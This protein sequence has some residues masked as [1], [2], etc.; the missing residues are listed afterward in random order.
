MR[1]VLFTIHGLIGDAIDE[2]KIDTTFDWNDRW[3]VKDKSKLL[4]AL[5]ALKDTEHLL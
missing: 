1:N 4:K 5:K 3:I 2:E